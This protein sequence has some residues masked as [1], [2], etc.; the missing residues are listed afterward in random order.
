ME[1]AKGFSGY[2]SHFSQTLATNA[3][4]LLLFFKNEIEVIV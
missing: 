3:V 2:L 4:P 1:N